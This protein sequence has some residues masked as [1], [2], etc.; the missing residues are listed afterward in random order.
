MKAMLMILMTLIILIPGLDADVM[1]DFRLP[2]ANNHD[3]RLSDILGKGPVLIEFWASW[4]TPC[5]ASMT[6]LDLLQKKYDSLTVVVISIDAPKDISKA[7]NYLKSKG[8]GF[9]AL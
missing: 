1:P 3:M 7:K 2:D 8:F 9:I 4:C 6:Q 5:K